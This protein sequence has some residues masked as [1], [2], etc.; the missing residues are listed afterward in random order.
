MTSQ[1]AVNE[2]QESLR[3]VN[4]ALTIAA[5][6]STVDFLRFCTIAQHNLKNALDYAHI[7]HNARKALL[8]AKHDWLPEEDL[9]AIID[10]GMTDNDIDILK[11]RLDKRVKD[12]TL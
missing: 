1:V 8:R 7:G 9:D 4:S 3:L 6:D 2:I 12:E 10:Y 11:Q 5:D